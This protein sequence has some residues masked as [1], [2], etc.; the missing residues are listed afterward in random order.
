MTYMEAGDKVKL[1]PGV[2]TMNT[3]SKSASYQER[4]QDTIRALTE[5]VTIISLCTPSNN[6]KVRDKKGL[7]FLCNRDDLRTIDPIFY[8]I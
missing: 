2:S 6:A 7:V 4:L 5:E 8:T 1:I 3:N